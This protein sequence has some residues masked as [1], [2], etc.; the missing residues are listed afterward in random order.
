MVL[1]AITADPCGSD[2]LLIKS[3]TWGVMKTTLNTANLAIPQNSDDE[4]SKKSS[5]IVNEPKT[6]SEDKSV[7]VIKAF[8]INI[9][10]LDPRLINDAQVSLKIPLHAGKGKIMG[11]DKDAKIKI[12]DGTIAEVDVRLSRNGQGILT[13]ESFSFALNHSLIIKNP[14][15]SLE[16]AK[17]KKLWQSKIKDKAADLKLRSICID[18]EGHV[19][20]NGKIK[21]FHTFTK[22][23]PHDLGQIPVPTLDEKLLASLGII[24]DVEPMLKDSMMSL[25]ARYQLKKLLKNLGAITEEA[26]YSIS[27]NAEPS[28]MLIAKDNNFFR[29]PTSPISLSLSGVVDLQAS[30]DLTIIIDGNKSKFAGSVGNHALHMVAKISHL[31]DDKPMNVN[32]H[33]ELHGVARDLRL[34]T[35]SVQQVKNVLPRRRQLDKAVPMPQSEDEYNTSFGASSVDVHAIVDMDVDISGLGQAGGK[36]PSVTL[37]NGEGRVE[38]LA[39]DPYARTHERGITMAGAVSATINSKDLRAGAKGLENAVVDASFGIYPNKMTMQQFPEVKASQF[40]YGISVKGPG[41]ARIKPPAYGLMR[42]IR[43]VKNFEGNDERIDTEVT[44]TNI[45]PIGSEKYYNQVQRITGLGIKKADKVELLIDG[46]R[47]MPKRLKLINAAKDTICFQT[48]AFKSDASGWQYAQA[49]VEAAKRGVKVYGIIDSLGNIEAFKDL[50][51]P[52]ELYAYLRD[53]GV[54][55]HLYNSFIEKGLRAIFAV[56]QNNPQA[57]S[58]PNA[59]SLMGVAE[60]LRFFE[61]AAKLADSTQDGLSMGDKRKLAEGIHTMLGGKKGVSPHNA[62]A[63]LKKAISDNMTTL[64]EVLLAIKRMGDATYRW[65]EKYLIIDGGEAIVGG[66]NIADEYLRGGSGEQVVI[67]GKAQPAWRD[68]D[69][70]LSGQVVEDVVKNFKN[71]WL[72][73]AKAKISIANT[74]SPS[75]EHKEDAYTVGMIH[76]RPW[77]DGDHNVTNFLLY[78]LR[79]LE[80][81]EKAWFETPYFLPR[82][83]LKALQQEMVKALKRGVDVRILTNSEKTSDFSALVEAA[84]FDTRELLEAGARIFHRNNERMLHAKVY[85]LGDKLTMIGSWNMDNRSAAH[86]SEDICAIYDQTITK[87]MSDQ[88]LIDMFEQSSEIKLSDLE[89]RSLGKEARSA[90]MLLMGDLL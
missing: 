64:D 12:K 15:A 85:V 37:N 49:L 35:F 82:G 6:L 55:L 21:A 83:A 47:S 52:N 58:A 41:R 79:T 78:N 51:K 11:I 42:F 20:V 9:I 23:L 63:E 54:E 68:S 69:V 72:H 28:H 43:P 7:S 66:M 60:L 40:H 10:G 88:L 80:P 18:K 75:P 36:R 84:V 57:F 44:R 76:H 70:Y 61:V 73:V 19:E 38:L 1:A 67:K 45:N 31:A 53:N 4:C 5:K 90:A 24:G 27:V 25:S 30:G 33:G 62:V 29:G 46:I 2:S 16:K 34:D 14:S 13:L 65:H 86:D 50:E 3:T 48:L 87:E 26:C 81:G 17:G 71:N 59:N 77:E 8:G 39:H 22:S 56:A 32:V 89:M 74:K